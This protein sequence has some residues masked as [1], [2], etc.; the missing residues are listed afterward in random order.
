MMMHAEII[1]QIVKPVVKLQCESHNLCDYSNA[2]I[3]VKRT[4]TITEVG[5]DA[6]ARQAKKINN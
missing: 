4:I 2:H 3:L 5:T 6:A 1:T